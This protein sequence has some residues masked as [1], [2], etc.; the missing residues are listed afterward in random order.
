M[1]IIDSMFAAVVVVDLVRVAASSVLVFGLEVF[2]SAMPRASLK[3]VIVKRTSIWDCFF[4]FW[5]KMAD[6]KLSTEF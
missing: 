6:S 1:V 4:P 2:D 5:V 3:Q